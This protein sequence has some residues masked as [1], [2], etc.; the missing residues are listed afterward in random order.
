[1][2]GD[3]SN[4]SSG[5]PAISANGRYVVFNSEGSN[6]VTNDTNRAVDTFVHDMQT[7]ATSR[8]N[9]AS[10]GSE[11]LRGPVFVDTVLVP[12]ISDDGRYMLFTSFA[13]NLVQEDLNDADDAFLHEASPEPTIIRVNA[14]GPAYTDSAGRLWS[15]DNGYNTGATTSFTD[16]IA[17]TTDDPLYQ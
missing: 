5:P 4:G 3:S 11:A 12:G 14:G 2:N 8:V 6:L 17:N 15:A 9:V 13:P 1:S 7:G 10:D 16:H